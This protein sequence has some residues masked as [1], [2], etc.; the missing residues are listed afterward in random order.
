MKLIQIKNSHPVL[1]IMQGGM[2]VGVSLSSLAGA[3]AKEGGIGIISSAQIGY[4][5]P[6]FATNTAE[7]NLRALQ[8]HI[9]RAKEISGGNGLVGVNVMH[10]LT[11]YK[12]HVETAAKAGADVIVCG[13]GLA[14]D[15]PALVV[16]TSAAIAPIV[17]SKKAAS[18]LFRSWSKKYHR[19]PDFLVIEGPKAGGHLGFSKEELS[20]LDTIPFEDEVR[21]IVAYVQEVSENAGT[22]IPV[23][24]AGG[25]RDR[26]AA[27]HAF[28]LGVDGIQVASR[29]VA[30]EECDAS[31]AYK[32]A[33]LHA[34][35]EQIHIIQS[36]VGMPGRA[37]ENEFL[38]KISQE[39]IPVKKCYH[40]IRNCNPAEIPYC[41]TKAL[42]D[43]VEGDVE[44]GLIFC[45]AEVG[46]I[47]EITT[48]KKVME[49]LLGTKLPVTSRNDIHDFVQT[50]RKVI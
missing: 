7:A 31:P 30:T 26:K 4:Q 42:I 10:A 32:E 24:L 14:I 5:E 47:H 13:A 29:F 8:K 34:K 27:E 49:E 50:I 28:S 21:S 15:L 17:S 11:N 25:I 46:S 36:P 2:G 33:Y 23:F 22:S 41:I 1:P 48:V 12:E 38:K 39:R 35:P 20:S 40:C 37:L 44:H 16:G 43:A 18:L 9:R 6:D 19:L 45:G 3:V